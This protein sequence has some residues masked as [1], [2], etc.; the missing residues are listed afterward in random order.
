MTP[1]LNVMEY[2][3]IK[4]GYVHKFLRLKFDT[5]YRY[6]VP[7]MNTMSNLVLPNDMLLEIMKYG[8][9]KMG[10]VN[11]FSRSKFNIYEHWILFEVIDSN[12]SYLDLEKI[13]YIY[14]SKHFPDKGLIFPNVVQILFRSIFVD[15]YPKNFPKVKQINL[16]DVVRS[17]TPK[18]ERR[19]IAFFRGCLGTP[20]SISSVI[21]EPCMRGWLYYDKDV[22]VKIDVMESG[23]LDKYHMEIFIM[24]RKCNVL[25]A[26]VNRTMYELLVKTD[27]RKYGKRAQVRLHKSFT[28]EEKRA[29]RMKSNETISVID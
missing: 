27:L 26:T 8:V 28:D 14:I 18:N 9:K 17:D 20:I 21:I 13:K 10:C 6:F 29:I 19:I 3:V 11:K 15:Y 23:V 7:E 22:N 12:L 25:R 5:F 2:I 4:I 24:Q 16:A 1:L